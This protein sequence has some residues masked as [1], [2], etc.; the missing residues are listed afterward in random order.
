MLA[1]GLGE[2]RLSTDVDGMAGV[3]VPGVGGFGEFLL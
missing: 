1:F 3:I 2:A